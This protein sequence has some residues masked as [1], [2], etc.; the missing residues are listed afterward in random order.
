[1]KNE[2]RAVFDRASETCGLTVDLA[3]LPPTHVGFATDKPEPCRWFGLSLRTIFLAIG[4]RYRTHR[5]Q[6]AL[7]ELSDDQLKDIG[8]S[9]SQ[10][11]G[12]HSRYRRAGSADV[13][14]KC[15]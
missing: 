7:Q 12:D 9:R 8:I 14:R 6:M 13:E 3:P 10:A 1:M 5:N 15:L 4:K 2:N 11:Y